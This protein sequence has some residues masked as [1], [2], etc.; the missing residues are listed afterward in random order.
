LACDFSENCCGVDLHNLR[1]P[2]F[3]CHFLELA[4][5]EFASNLSKISVANTALNTVVYFCSRFLCTEFYL[6][7]Y[8]SPSRFFVGKTSKFLKNANFFVARFK[9][10]YLKFLP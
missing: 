7:F 3:R 9:K 2:S 4:F 1:K 8:W 6:P 10:P 5:S